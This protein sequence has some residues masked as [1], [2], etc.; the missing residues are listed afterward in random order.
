MAKQKQIKIASDN[1]AE[2]LL[3]NLYSQVKGLTSSAGVYMMYSDGNA[4]LYVGKAKDLV[5]RLK[6][7]FLGQDKRPKIKYLMDQVNSLKILPTESEIEA[8][9][10]EN[11]WIKKLKPKYNVLLKDDKTFPYIKIDN[12]HSFPRVSLSR[13]PKANDGNSYFGPFPS[14]RIVFETI[15]IASKI[16]KLRDCKDGEFANRS[17]PCLS[18]QMNNCTAPCVGLVDAKDYNGQLQS[19]LDFVKQGSTEIL[20]K[21]EVDMKNASEDLQ[22]EL[23]AELRDRI[24]VVN[25]LHVQKNQNIETPKDWIDRDLWCS[26]QGDD[27]TNQKNIEFVILQFRSNRWVGQLS[28]SLCN[29]DDFL[30]LEDLGA[31]ILL[32]H[33][34]QYSIPE[35][36]IVS[37][38]FPLK[39][40][41]QKLIKHLISNQVQQINSDE[42]KD[43]ESLA[44]KNI[45]TMDKKWS[46]VWDMGINIAKDK[47]QESL[48][49]IKEYDLAIKE[50]CL[51]LKLKSSPK[52]IDCIDISHLQGRDTVGSAVVFENGQPDKSKYRKY[53]IKSLAQ[54]KIDDYSSLK[55]LVRRR[56]CLRADKI[57]DLLIVDG[58][59]GQLNSVVKELDEFNVQFHVIS[60]A[61]AREIG[62]FKNAEVE[63]SN[64]RIFVPNRKNPII[65]KNL[66]LLR[67]VTSLRDEAHRFAISFY[68]QKS[69]KK[70]KN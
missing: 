4:C 68:R 70:H 62:N 5:S 33:Y 37:K 57:P 3:D 18:Y 17:R 41:K 13:R 16:F 69:T 40:N 20:A 30:G 39:S 2:N 49:Q 58:G 27:S 55:E 38:Q 7:Y 52:I 56:Y 51:K 9:I 14:S 15:K 23:A 12:S 47:Y 42:I 21:W 35:E 54:F 11:H 48:Q 63:Y 64:E 45:S 61:K 32:S 29:L 43:R 10:L 8:L 50:L 6:N 53:N 28:K 26:F 22:F 19:F 1:E 31:R 60:L 24:E 66:P 65:V 46:L 44:I 59:K 36:I 67:L 34:G 25:K